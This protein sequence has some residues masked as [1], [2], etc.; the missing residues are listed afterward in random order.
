M[1]LMQAQENGDVLNEEDLAF[2]ARDEGN[3]FDA[4]VDDQPVQDLALNDPN[5]F[6]ADDCDAFDLDVDNE[7]IA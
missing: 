6:Q 3:T 4:Y 5:I 2:L 7:P 1:L